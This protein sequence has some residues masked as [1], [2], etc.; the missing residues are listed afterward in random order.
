MVGLEFDPRVQAVIHRA[1]DVGAA[2]DGDDVDDE[3]STDD[4][5]A[6]HINEDD[7]GHRAAR[8]SALTSALQAV[9]SSSEDRPRARARHVPAAGG[10]VVVLGADQGEPAAAAALAGGAEMGALAIEI[11][12]GEATLVVMPRRRGDGTTSYASA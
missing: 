10:G 6:G 1:S 8:A 12:H 11:V 9:R 7:E 3:K 2:N 4:D 5:E